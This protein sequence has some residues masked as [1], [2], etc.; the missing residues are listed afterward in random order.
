MQNKL[1]D[2]ADRLKKRSPFLNLRGEFRAQF[3]HPQRRVALREN[4]KKNPDPA[5]NG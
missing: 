3:A 1:I 5:T 2:A 4:R